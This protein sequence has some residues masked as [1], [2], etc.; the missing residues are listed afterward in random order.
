MR[1]SSRRGRMLAHRRDAGSAEEKFLSSGKIIRFRIFSAASESRRWRALRNRNSAQCRL[2]QLSNLLIA[3]RRFGRGASRAVDNPMPFQ[4][5]PSV[6]V[7]HKDW[8]I[9]GIQQN[10]VGGLWPDAI[11]R[12][13]FVAEFS[14]R[15]G[16]HARQRA[17]VA[18]IEKV[19]EGFQPLRFLPEVARRTDQLLQLRLRCAANSADRKKSRSPEV[20]QRLLN[21]CP[22]RVLGLIRPN[23]HLKTRLC[24]PPVLTSP[25][26]KQRV[27]VG[28]DC[29][30]AGFVHRAHDCRRRHSSCELESLTT[31]ST[32]FHR[33][34]R[35]NRIIGDGWLKR[36]PR[37]P[38]CSLW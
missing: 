8:M 5:A 12:Q 3:C 35:V 37:A 17:A 34:H 14:R 2:K 27:V 19:H 23:N 6:S 9:A 20:A 4:N 18:L 29:V 1:S 13:Q 21:V 7:H 16:Q 24:R 36:P 31:G 32:G 28:A 30:L 22:R 33:G 10:R 26:G 15:S 25:G 38:L 11:E